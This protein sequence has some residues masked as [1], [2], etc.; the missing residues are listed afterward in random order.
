MA[1][2]AGSIGAVITKVGC[3]R[4]RV[5]QTRLEMLGLKSSRCEAVSGCGKAPETKGGGIST[6]VVLCSNFTIQCSRMFFCFERFKKLRD[7]RWYFVGTCHEYEHGVAVGKG[8]MPWVLSHWGR[9]KVPTM[10]QVLSLIQCIC[11]RKTLGSN[12]GRQTCFLSLDPSNLGTPLECRKPCHTAKSWRQ[13]YL[14]AHNVNFQS[15]PK[16]I[17]RKLMLWF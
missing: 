6:E 1:N 11:C 14:E 17:Q 3:Q 12:T 13:N 5:Q 15:L 4:L 2:E 9:S 10:S 16:P 7:N 8:T